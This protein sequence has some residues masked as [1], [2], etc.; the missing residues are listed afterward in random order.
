MNIDDYRK[1][2]K[3]NKKLLKKECFEWK[4]I[5]DKIISECE[6]HHSDIDKVSSRLAIKEQSEAIN[7]IT[8]KLHAVLRNLDG[9]NNIDNEFEN[10][11]NQQ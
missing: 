3:H 10:T 7:A 11:N 9:T 2:I 6:Y 5:I 8:E 1:I 4:A